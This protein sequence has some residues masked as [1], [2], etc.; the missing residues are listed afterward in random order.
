MFIW[1]FHRISGVALIVLIGIKILTSF[2]L[3][4]RDNKPDWALSLHRQP[5]LDIF[6]LV[7]FTFHSIYGL[8]TII[9]DLG[10]RK[11]K[12]LFW[13]SNMAAALISCALIYTYLVLS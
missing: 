3:L 6:I 1:L 2:F 8:R 4:A 10:C 5:V 11:E 9:I 13:W 12:S 7:L